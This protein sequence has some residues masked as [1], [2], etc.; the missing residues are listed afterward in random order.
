LISADALDK[1]L[2]AGAEEEELAA[3]AGVIR[4][5][6]RRSSGERP[7]SALQA[8]LRDALG[9]FREH[10]P[11]EARLRAEP[12]LAA[13]AAL[14]AAL[15]SIPVD[16]HGAPPSGRRFAATTLL[17]EFDR[18]VL[19]SD[20]LHSLLLLDRAASRM[21]AGVDELDE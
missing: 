17:Y 4:S 11:R 19:E 3:L 16:R 18:H 15:D 13:A 20:T 5:E 1:R 21:S 2:D 10:G 7:A 6:L 9:A 8:A 14:V 12:A